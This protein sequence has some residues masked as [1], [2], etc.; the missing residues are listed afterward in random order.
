MTWHRAGAPDE[1]TVVTYVLEK[2]D[3]GTRLT[4]GHSGFTCAENLT[5]VAAGWKTSFDKL[6]AGMGR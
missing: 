5:N 2:L 1:P 3:G 4:L 6:A